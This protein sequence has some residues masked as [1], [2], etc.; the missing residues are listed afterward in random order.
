MDYCREGVFE[1]GK[2]SYSNSRRDQHSGDAREQTEHGEDGSMGTRDEQQMLRAH[3][4]SYLIPIRLIMNMRGMLATS[5]AIATVAVMKVSSTGISMTSIFK[6]TI[7]NYHSFPD[8]K[9][10]IL[11]LWGSWGIIEVCAL[12]FSKGVS[13][14]LRCSR[15]RVRCHADYGEVEG[16]NVGPGN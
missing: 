16:K 13:V 14:F 3:A 15:V 7:R 1:I 12:T 11:P 8:N 4:C 5:A 10:H 2:W 6:K 9:D